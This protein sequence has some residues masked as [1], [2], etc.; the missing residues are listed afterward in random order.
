MAAA[1]QK[2]RRRIIIV[3]GIFCAVC[4]AL[5]FRVGWIQIVVGEE[6]AKLAI[7]QQTKDMPIP[8]KRGII[9]DRNG[10]ELA[11]CA[12]TN[13]IW[14]RP[15]D[16]Q[17]SKKMSVEEIAESLSGI[18]GKDTAEVKATLM[19]ENKPLLKIAKYVSKEKADEIRKAQLPGISIVEDVKRYYPLGA[20]AA[21]ILGS[22]TDDNRGLAGIELKYDRFLSGIPGRSIKNTDVAGQNLPYGTEKYFQ[23]ENGYN[24]VLTIDEVIQHYVEK[25]VQECREATGAK[26]VMCLVMQPETGDILGMA[27]YPDFDPNDPRT[28]LDPA[29]AEYVKTLDDIQKQEYW[30][31]MW[32]NPMISDTYEPGST[33][34]LITTAMAL[35]EGVTTPNDTFT[36]TGYYSIGNETLRCWRYYNPHGLETLTEAVQNSCNPVFMELS[37]R[38]GVTR[39]YHYLNAFGFTEKTGIDFPGETNALLQKE[40]NVVPVALAT[41]SYGQGISITPIQLITAISAIGND[42]RLM[43]PRLV[44]E[45][46]DDS[47]NTVRIFEPSIV[48]QVLSKET[49]SEMLKIMEAVVEDGTGATARILGYRIGGKTGTADKVIDGRYADGKVYSSFVAMAPIDDPE[50][51]ILMIVDEPQGVHF[52][53]QTAAPAVRSILEESLRYM[54]IQPTYTP[55]E[56]AEIE[57]TYVSVPDITGRNYSEGAGLLQAAGLSGTVWP[58]DDGMDFVIVDQYPKG[59]EKIKSGAAVFVYK[60]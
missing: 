26:R 29:E 6:Y 58:D 17:A 2:N 41:I 46:Q 15:A 38:M 9:Y 32:R 3:F 18:L 25:S 54:K 44:K 24:A 1:T 53:S 42:G 50:L 57:K 11:V 21:H 20:F 23:A 12:V 55:D 27:V 47:G 51:A 59:G 60:K 28:P 39:Y 45:L 22:T 13:T 4:V 49:S 52:G 34:K 36:C 40:E 19:N 56:L 5:T 37:R 35:E 14:V 7:E 30:N 48:R 8:A 33:F 43:R 10:K 16:A 31:S